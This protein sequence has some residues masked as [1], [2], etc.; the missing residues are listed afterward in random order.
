[1]TYL[2]K[3][4]TAAVGGIT[5]AA[6]P[7]LLFG[8]MVSTTTA[9]ATQIGVGIGGAAVLSWIRALGPVHGF[10]WLI[11]SVI[12]VVQ[13]PIRRAISTATPLPA[14]PAAVARYPGMARYPAL[15]AMYYTGAFGRYYNAPRSTFA[16]PA[17]GGRMRARAMP[18]R[19]R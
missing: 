18:V 11:G 5:S 4:G 19:A 17:F 15:G 2:P 8:P 12:G 10:A 7:S 16:Q 14:P 3:L 6:A 13:E 1:M 9:Y